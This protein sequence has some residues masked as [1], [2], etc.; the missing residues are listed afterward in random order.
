MPWAPSRAGRSGDTLPGVRRLGL[1]SALRVPLLVALLGLGLA[2]GGCKGR[3]GDRASTLNELVPPKDAEPWESR[4]AVAFDDSYTP[5]AVNLQGR[6]P[7][8]VTDQQL[9]Q[10][11]LG[12]AQ[13]V[14]LVR[15]EQV[16]GK[17]RYQGRQDQFIEVEIGEVLLGSLPKNAPEQIM[18]EVA[19]T[20]ELPGS[21]KDEP[22]LLFLRW[23]L[24]SEP[25]YHHHLMPADEDLVA[26]INAMVKH[27]QNEGVLNAKGDEAS[28]G[29]RRRARKKKDK[30]ANK[31]RG[32][33]KDSAAPDD[34]L[35]A[36]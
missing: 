34:D 26:L 28:D 20:D 15:I 10:A 17:G 25:A 29:E 30:K 8:D 27:A 19:S 12:Y 11:R 31:K 9:F 5:T 4:Y 32:K 24:D 23:D 3:R 14:L 7:N 36:E 33:S 16:W 35:P 21:L 1:A 6:A 13:I 2:A 22:M 18:V